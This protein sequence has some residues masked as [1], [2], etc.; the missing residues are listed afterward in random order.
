MSNNDMFCGDEVPGVVADLGSAFIKMGDGGQDS[1]RHFFP[2]VVGSHINSKDITRKS[3]IGEV[4][5]NSV[6][7]S[8]DIN[9]PITPYCINWSQVESL[10]EYGLYDC[11]KIDPKIY[12]ILLS[13]NY[14]TSTES[15][16]KLFEIMFEKFST[17]ASYI[18]KSGTLCAVASG[19]PTSLVVDF[20]ATQTRIIP[21]VDG[22]VLNKAVVTTSRGGNW[23]DSQLQKELQSLGY[24]NI[25]SRADIINSSSISSS[26]QII[27]TLSASTREFYLNQLLRDI[28]VSLCQVPIHSSPDSTSTADSA[29]ASVARDVTPYELPDKTVIFPVDSLCNLPERLLH[30]HSGRMKQ[31][32]DTTS[33]PG[34]FNLPAHTMPLDIQTE[35]DSLAELVYASLSKSDV[36]VR[37]ALISNI[38]LVGGGVWKG[39]PQRLATELTAMLPVTMKVK[40]NPMMPIERKYAAWIGGSILSICGT[41]QQMWISKAQ[42]EESGLR[43]LQS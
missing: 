19:R 37:K 12:P 38:L 22:Y 23:I 28:K 29:D 3:V 5:L 36:D 24:N 13:E 31:K 7:E 41:F 21:V 15:K 8:I 43:L 17:P 33:S 42:Y 14:F 10:L 39:S 1:P 34:I 11:M 32:L 26:T 40:V 4:S 35:T 18:A 9:S 27:S 6:R 25:R 30:S 20:G 16:E 2:S